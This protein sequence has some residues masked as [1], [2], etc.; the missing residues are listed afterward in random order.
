MLFNMESN[1]TK[2]ELGMNYNKTKAKAKAK[3]EFKNKNKYSKMED[4]C[5]G[6]AMVEDNLKAVLFVKGLAEAQKV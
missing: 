2:E 6:T 4:K 5:C 3:T 1:N